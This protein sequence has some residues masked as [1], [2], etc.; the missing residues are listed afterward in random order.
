MSHRL[1]ASEMEMWIPF[2]S[3]NLQTVTFAPFELYVSRNI[4][5]S[6]IKNSRI[7]SFICNLYD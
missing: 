1:L 2:F 4:F 5:K 6:L 3:D 7:S